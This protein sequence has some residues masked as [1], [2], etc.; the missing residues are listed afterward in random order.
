MFSSCFT[1][2]CIVFAEKGETLEGVAFGFGN[3][4]FEA[5]LRNVPMFLK[6][7]NS[8]MKYLLDN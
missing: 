1:L 5:F 3:L 4:R 6:T 2:E 8:F 7:N